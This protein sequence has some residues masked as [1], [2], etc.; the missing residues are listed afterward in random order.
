MVGAAVNCTSVVPSRSFLTH[1]CDTD[2]KVI[3]FLKKENLLGECGVGENS[4]QQGMEGVGRKSE[5]RE[6][7]FG[8]CLEGSVKLCTQGVG[9]GYYRENSR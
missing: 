3:L 8:L 6:T 7:A 9:D 4:F 5:P 2:E 1:K